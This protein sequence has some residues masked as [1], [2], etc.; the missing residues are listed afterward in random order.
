MGIKAPLR[1]HV[2]LGKGLG[3]MLLN[4]QRG[5]SGPQGTQR[6]DFSTVNLTWSVKRTLTSE[7][8]KDLGTS[9]RLQKDGIFFMVSQDATLG[10]EREGSRGKHSERLT[11]I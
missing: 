5:L 7:A 6:L 11:F 8:G 3:L 2:Y 1:K 4:Q 9:Q 10:R